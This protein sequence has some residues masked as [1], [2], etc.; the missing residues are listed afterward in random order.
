MRGVRHMMRVAFQRLI[1]E[2]SNFQQHKKETS[3][4]VRGVK[5]WALLRGLA[6]PFVW[7]VTRWTYAV[8]NFNAW[9]ASRA[10]KQLARSRQGKDGDI[11]LLE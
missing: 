5:R 1:I 2:H 8:E 3:G 11:P 7:S 10:E 6:Y 4:R 9:R